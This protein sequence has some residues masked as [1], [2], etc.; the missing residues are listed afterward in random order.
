MHCHSPKMP[1]NP[2]ADTPN[3]RHHQLLILLLISATYCST[4]G[5][6][7]FIINFCTKVYKFA[8]LILSL[9]HCRHATV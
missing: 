8:P 6:P 2:L 7:D 3:R 1:H 4:Q 5:K 9:L